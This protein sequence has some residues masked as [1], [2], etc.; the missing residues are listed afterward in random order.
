MSFKPI[1]VGDKIIDKDATY[2]TPQYRCGVVDSVTEK[3]LRWTRT[4]ARLMG[5]QQSVR[6]DRHGVFAVLPPETDMAQLQERLMAAEDECNAKIKTLRAQ[7][8]SLALVAGG[9]A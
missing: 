1:K 7:L 4:R 8:G 5:E 2:F 6:R 9:V 3:T